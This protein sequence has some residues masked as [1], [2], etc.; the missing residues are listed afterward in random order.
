MSNISKGN[1]Y[2]NKVKK[3]LEERGWL[4]EKAVRTRYNKID[5][6]GW[7]DLIAIREQTILFIQVKMNKASKKYEEEF[8]KF[9]KKHD[10]NAIL[11]DNCK[12]EKLFKERLTAT[13]MIE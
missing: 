4:V 7:F 12:N 2:E 6:F 13:N 3:A 1:Y 11:W 8:M 5:F 10:L 9:A